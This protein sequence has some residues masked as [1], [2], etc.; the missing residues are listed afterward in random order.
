[1]ELCDSKLYCFQQKLSECDISQTWLASVIATGAT[2]IVKIPISDGEVNLSTCMS[3]LSNSFECQKQLLS[4]EIIVTCRK[5]S[6]GGDDYYEYPH[7]N[8]E[9]W[10]HLTPG[11]FWSDYPK[12]LVQACITIDYLHLLGLVHADLKLENFLADVSIK[13]SRLVLIDLDFLCRAGSSPEAM[14]FG[15]PEHIAPEILSNDKVLPQ[16]DH[17]SLG[18]SLKRFMNDDSCPDQGSECS[19]TTS[20]L[21]DLV[22]WLTS[23]DY[24]ERPS[25]LLEALHKT[26]ILNDDAFQ[27]S[28]QQL[29]GKVLLTRWRTNTEKA[30]TST[31]GL[32]KFIFTENKILGMRDDL[33]AAFSSAA[34]VSRRATFAVFRRMFEHSIVKRHADYWHLM[35]PDDVL[36]DVY[37]HLDRICAGAG[38]SNNSTDA[39]SDRSIEEHITFASELENRG[40]REWSFLHL[41]KYLADCDS[42]G[43]ARPADTMQK[44]ISILATLARTLNR[45]EEAATYLTKL[46][47]S[48]DNTSENTAHVLDLVRV[49]Q[50]LGRLDQANEVVERGLK[51]IDPSCIDRDTLKLRLT[52]AWMVGAYG[53][54]EDASRQ[55]HELLKTASENSHYETVLQCHYSLGV[56]DWRKGRYDAAEEALLM[57]WHIAQEHQIEAEAVAVL[58]TLS[59]VFSELGEYTKS[60]KFGK[61]AMVQATKPEHE[62]LRASICVGIGYAYTRLAEF[63]KAEHWHQRLLMYA[64]SMKSQKY[65]FNYYVGNGFVALNQGRIVDAKES[66]HKALTI[67]PSDLMPKDMGKVHQHLADIALCQGDREAFDRHYDRAVSEVRE[68]GDDALLAELELLKYLY[69]GYYDGKL[70]YKCLISQVLKLI[71]RNCRYYATIA[72]FHLLLHRAVEMTPAIRSMLESIRVAKGDAKTPLSI[73]VGHLVSSLQGKTEWPM[74]MKSRKDAF[75]VLLHAK[76]KFVTMLLG[77]KIANDYQESDKTKHARKYMLLA[78][79]LASGLSNEYYRSKIQSQLDTLDVNGDNYD[80]LVESFH[81]VSRILGKIDDYPDALNRLVQFAL[82]ETGAERG[83][84]LLRQS[85]KTSLFIET[86]INVDGDSFEDIVDFSNKMPIDAMTDNSPLIVENALNDKRTRD[87]HSVVSHN[88]LSVVCVPLRDGEDSIGILYL[89]HHSVPALFGPSDVKYILAIANFISAMLTVVRGYRSV[90]LSNLQ[91]RHELAEVGKHGSFLTRDTSMIMLLERLPKIAL[92]NVPVLMTGESG[93]GKEILCRRIHE[94]SH[95]SKGPMV[96][97]NCAAIASS[98][99]EAELFGIAGKVATGVSEREGKLSAADG[100][101]LFLDEIGD[102]SLDIQAKIL[103][104]VEYQQ[105]EKVGSNLT[106]H[107]DVR[108]MYATNKD[109]PALI[110]EGKFRS[111]LYYRISTIILEI[112]PLR[113]RPDDIP[114]LIEHFIHIV[115]EKGESPVFSSG[116]LECLLSYGWPGNVRELR[117]FVERCSIL[118]SGT[119][120]RREMLPPEMRD[121]STIH[122]AAKVVAVAAES[123]KMRETLIA[124]DGNQS[125]AARRMQLPLSTFRRKMKKYGISRF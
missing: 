109:I 72:I 96:K 1:M 110:K 54:Y 2:V 81:A 49:Y 99:A 100:G 53:N 66:L 21:T 32:K 12:L 50:L 73:A 92:T 107:S 4:S 59:L 90:N 58:S 18:I 20:R 111:D 114:L 39:R 67:A 55:L 52:K 24:L 112:P 23:Q 120:V 118:F 93:T 105:Y 56:L 37:E 78:H 108:F 80:Q 95:R 43:E 87:Y 34:L 26:G 6:E 36:L 14:V 9:R 88:I 11:L 51:D 102:M 119:N 62:M 97:L 61:I 7:F 104:V 116:A 17:Y 41:K 101:T 65:L 45:L 38:P 15:S 31:S 77:L 60:A 121:A 113:K 28:L 42:D 64:S 103:H 44:V 69:C 83:V 79:E 48:S 16:S 33:I 19:T 75:A 29:L 85:H 70:E 123:T 115:A 13:P 84:L 94:L 91:L 46:V 10:N 35:S 86:A 106:Q 117:N 82:D 8:A 47:E 125:K 124:C 76:A 3:I 63:E 30:E 89:D 68:I 27:E 122:G 40:Y 25:N 71:S 98:L 74:R 5:V 57:A 22:T